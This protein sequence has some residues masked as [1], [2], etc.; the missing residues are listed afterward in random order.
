MQPTAAKTS[1]SGVSCSALVDAMAR[2]YQHRAHIL[3]LVS[4][5]PARQLFGPAATIIFLPRRDDLDEDDGSGFDGW[6]HRA[7]GRDP[8]GTILAM[9][10]GGFPDASH[11]GSVKLSRLHHHGLAGLLTDGRLRDFSELSEYNFVTWCRGETT[12]WG[13]DVIT[14]A[15]AGV[16][17][18]V[19]GVRIV[20]GD[21]LYADRAGAV[22]IPAESVDD[23]IREARAIQE[24]DTSAVLRIKAGRPEPSD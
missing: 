24:E 12:K 21:Y 19:G 6:F 10:H 17:I 5:N 2:R 18:E 20:P 22:V 3:D 11:G 13:G 8:R 7:V 14:P 23:V 16:P 4:P 15:A 9:S 1:V